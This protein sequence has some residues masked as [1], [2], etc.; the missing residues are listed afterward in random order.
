MNKKT[1]L[2]SMLLILSFLLAENALAQA[3]Y[4]HYETT[5]GVKVAYRWQ[6]SSFFD[7]NSDAVINFEF[8]N[9]SAFPVEVSFDLGFYRD[10]QLFLQ[11]EDNHICLLPGQTRRGFRAGLRFTAEGINLAMTREDWFSW[12][13][14]HFEVR[15]VSDCE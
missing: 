8:T 15:E 4:L 13:F 7:K 5:E 2:S 12:D 3:R 14:V 1:M 6:R 9:E 10:H 11:S